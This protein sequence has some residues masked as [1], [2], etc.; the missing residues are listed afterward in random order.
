[1]SSL[2]TVMV[3]GDAPFITVTEKL[4]SVLA[5]GSKV[6]EKLVTLASLGAL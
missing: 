5:Y 1:M 6:R 2:S 4:N 3:M